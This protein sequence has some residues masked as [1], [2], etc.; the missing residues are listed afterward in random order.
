MSIVVPSGFRLAGV[1]CGIKEDSSKEDL[2]LVVSDHPAVSAA[3]YT[4]NRIVAAPVVLDRRRTPSDQFRVLVVNSGN[5]NACTGERGLRDAE[6]MAEL[7]AEACHAAPA[8]ALVMS[9]GVIGSFLPMEKI[10]KGVRAAARQLGADESHFLTAAR[11]ILTT[12]KSH[13]VASR[14]LRLQSDT[15]RVLGMAK[16]A[17]MIGPDMATMLAVILTDA[18]LL[19][20]D[21]QRVVQH[22]VDESFNCISVEGHTSTNDTVL[23]LASGKGGPLSDE[24]L[25]DLEAAV[26]EVCVELARM[27]PDDGEGASHL[28]TIKVSGCADRQSALQIARTV[29]DSALVKTG[30]AGADPNWGRIVS[31]AG[32]AGVPFDPAG[33][34]LSLNGTCVFRNGAPVAFD[35]EVVSRSLRENRET[36]VDLEFSEGSGKAHF[37]SS[38][39]T[40]DYVRFNS[41]YT[42]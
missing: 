17:G 9:T 33:L 36:R 14:E 2:T 3:V 38:D 19:P 37:W 41:E 24:A 1:H 11:G 15:I 8:Q 25:A 28:I 12:D 10:A 40:M 23:L 13:K 32:Y 22:A 26:R 42:T 39:L 30:I 7:A 34:S 31:A 27:I 4:Q 16:G 29:A 21:A 20:A 18:S 6:A 5:A 35:T